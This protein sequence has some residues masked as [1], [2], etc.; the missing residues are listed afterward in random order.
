MPEAGVV[1]WQAFSALS[2]GRRFAQGV[3]LPIT[4][5]ELVAYGQITGLPFGARHFALIRA[6]DA[7]W[8]EAARSDRPVI[9]GELSGDVFDAIFA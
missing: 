9:A 7:V 8:L 2:D 3:P 6:L 5:A 1:F 4:A